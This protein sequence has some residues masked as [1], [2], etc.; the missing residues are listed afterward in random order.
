[1]SDAKAVE[2]TGHLADK[3]LNNTALLWQS[4]ATNALQLT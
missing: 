1:M 2:D 4:I 3:Q